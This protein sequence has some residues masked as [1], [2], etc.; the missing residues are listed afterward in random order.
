MNRFESEAPRRIRREPR[1]HTT[2]KPSHRH[3]RTLPLRVCA[4]H[5][6]RRQAS[7]LFPPVVASV[8]QARHSV[9]AQARQWGFADEST[10]AE[11]LVSE[12]LAN[13]LAHTE[14]PVRVRMSEGDGALRLEV[15]EHGA[16]T[17][18]PPA[19][20]SGPDEESGRGLFLLETL[21]REWG[22]DGTRTGKVVWFEVAGEFG[23]EAAA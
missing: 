23:A 3:P 7:W 6:W 4:G 12:V 5:G 10:T 8:P 2:Y 20:L 21:S 1:R 16:A 9:G 22:V 15:E 19:R 13:A 14:E 18:L 11:L 17:P